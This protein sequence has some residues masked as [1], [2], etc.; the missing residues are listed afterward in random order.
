MNILEETRMLN[1]K[2]VD[3]PTD[4]NI[5]LVLDQGESYPNPGRYKP[6]VGKLNYLSVTHPNIF[7]ATCVASQFLNSPCQNHW[8][9][10]LQIQIYIKN[11]P[12]KVL[13]MKMRGI[14]KLLGI[15][16]LIG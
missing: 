6:L 13:T 2:P 12:Y 7:F 4:P 14:P 15:L 10:V 9:V 8:D 5:N 11:V 3:T 16:M 1:T